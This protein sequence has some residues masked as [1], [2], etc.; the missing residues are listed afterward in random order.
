VKVSGEPVDRAKAAEELSGVAEVSSTDGELLIVFSNLTDSEL[1]DRV[2]ERAIKR[3]RVTSTKEEIV[4][5][6]T[7][8]TS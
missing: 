8:G 4:V 6:A 7:F 3:I 2:V 1:Q 5:P